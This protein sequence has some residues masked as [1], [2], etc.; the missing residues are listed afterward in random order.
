MTDHHDRLLQ[1]GEP[2][3][4]LELIQ[5]VRK[6]EREAFDEVFRR[7]APAVLRYARTVCRDEHVAQDLV[8]ET[9]TRTL[10]AVLNGV[11]PDTAVRAYLLASV[12]SVA[13]TWA[14]SA[15]RTTPVGDFAD[16]SVREVNPGDLPALVDPG[17][18]VRVL[19]A[20][21]QSLAVRAFRSL[22]ERWQR[23]LW[24]TDVQRMS[25]REVAPLLG[26]APNAVSALAQRAR[27]GL[28]QAYLQIQVSATLTSSPECALCAEQ[29]AAHTRGKLG[30]RAQRRLRDHLEAC[31]PC[32]A[33]ADELRKVNQGLPALTPIDL[34]HLTPAERD[35]LHRLF[36]TTPPPAAEDPRQEYEYEHP[37]ADPQS[38]PPSPPGPSWLQRRLRALRRR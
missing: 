14:R 2:P 26:L 36:G 15:G 5:R 17:A 12:R 28:R 16:V 27:E 18:D 19:R 38:A 1:P 35:Y 10:R 37:A 11:G 25:P 3:S 7:H 24:H 13:A 21:E 20:E 22:P 9:F 4:D 6:G 32:Q 8:A 31:E 29:L 33:I 30:K 23:V 34:R